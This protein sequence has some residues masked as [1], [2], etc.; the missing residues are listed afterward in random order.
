MWTV[1]SE[2]ENLCLTIAGHD[3]GVCR[4]R[5]SIPQLPGDRLPGAASIAGRLQG[6]CGG[7]GVSTRSQE[8]PPDLQL[9]V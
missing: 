1:N 3:V 6:V 9:R 5:G 2:C 4:A 8:W 7:T